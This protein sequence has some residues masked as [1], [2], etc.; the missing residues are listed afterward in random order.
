MFDRP[1]A[2]GIAAGDSGE[3][4]GIPAIAAPRRWVE[5]LIMTDTIPDPATRP[6]VLR[7]GDE[8]RNHVGHR[9]PDRSCTAVHT[10]SLSPY[11]GNLAPA[12]SLPPVR[13][14]PNFAAR[15]IAVQPGY[16]F[17]ELGRLPEFLG[18][19]P[20]GRHSRLFRLFAPEPAARRHFAILAAML[21]RAGVAARV[22]HGSRALAGRFRSP[23]CWARFPA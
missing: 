9:V 2:Y 17:A 19:R 14:P 13:R 12:R 4:A 3:A 6:P 23:P 22:L 11:R 16:G 7:P 1:G 20:D 18:E 10:I 15:P 8:G 21:N 5:D